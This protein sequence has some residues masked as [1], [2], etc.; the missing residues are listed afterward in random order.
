VL[1][2]EE[3]G[4]VA[5]VQY[6]QE[7]EARGDIT[8]GGGVTK[9]SP[10]KTEELKPDKGVNADRES[11]MEEGS[12]RSGGWR[13]IGQLLEH[14]GLQTKVDDHRDWLADQIVTRT[15]DTHSSGCY[16][17]IAAQC[18]DSLVFEALAL[19]EEARR[20]GSIRQSR[21]ALFVTIV[22]RLCAERGLQ[23]PLGKR[24]APA[25]VSTRS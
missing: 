18:P 21:G 4:E 23:D 3:P 2:I 12:P 19:L 8:V 9:L 15:G 14:D 20:D 5:V 17:L 13:P 16:R 24:P 11:H 22:R 6:R 1:I 7:R 10:H 25:G